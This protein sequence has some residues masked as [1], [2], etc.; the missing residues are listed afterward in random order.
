MVARKHVCLRRLGR[1]RKEAVRFGRFLANPRVTAARVIES[2]GERIGEAAVGRHILAVQDTSEIKFATTP[3]RRRGLG[4]VGKGNIHGVLLH[5]MMALDAEDGTCLGL[6]TGE[7]W[8]RADRVSTPHDQRPLSQKESQRWLTTAEKAKVVLA[9]AAMVTIIADRESDIYAE[10]ASVPSPNVHLITRVMHDR[11]LSD[12]SG[13]Y[14]AGPTLPA[15]GTT[16]LD[17]PARPGRPARR[18]QVSL[19]CGSVSLRRPNSPWLRHLPD[20]VAL[21]LVEVVETSAPG[22]VDAIHWR[23]L[24]THR[25]ATPDDAWRI[26]TWYKARWTIEQLFRVLKTQGL[27]LED[28]QLA[29]AAGLI[30]LVAVAAK[31]AV[32]IIQLTQARGGSRH[33]ATIVFDAIQ[34]DALRAL[35]GTLEGLTKLQKNPHPPDSLAWAAWTIARLGGWDGYPSSKPPGPITFKH[36]LEYFRP[37][38]EGWLLRDVCMP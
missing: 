13:L 15:L 32:I 35:N 11:K 6:V 21:M 20:S 16:I 2:W 7:I 4:E 29:S 23:L 1:R 25:I 8:T 10:W 9:G 17:L 3:V 30:K 19:R 27:K 26:V 34:R 31:A 28:S 22:G 5:A 37:L 24:T 18:A 14:A 33:P 36:G 12:G 38:A